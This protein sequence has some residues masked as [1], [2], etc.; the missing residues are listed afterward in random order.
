MKNNIGQLDMRTL[1]VH[2][3]RKIKIQNPDLRQ[4]GTIQIVHGLIE[5]DIYIGQ[6]QL[7][8]V[9]LVNFGQL[10]KA[11][12]TIENVFTQASQTSSIVGCSFHEGQGKFLRISNSNKISVLGNVFYSGIKAL[13]EIVDQKYLIFKNNILIHVKKAG[14]SN[15]A[16][17]ANFIFSKS[18]LNILRSNLD[19]T[20]NI[21][22]GSE[23]T[24]FYIVS[25]QCNQ[26]D[27]ANIYNNVCSSA[28]NACFAVVQRNSACDAISDLYAYHSKIGIMFSVNSRQLEIKKFITA[29]NKIN[30][31]LKGSSINEMNNVIKISDGYITAIARPTCITC[32]ENIDV[33]YCSS[34]LGMQLATMSSQSFL[35]TVDNLQSDQFDWINT[36]QVIDLRVLVNNLEFNQFKVN[37]N[38]VPN[39]VENAVFRQH[40]QAIDM[41]GRHYLKNTLC[42]DCEFESL[43]YRL[44][45]SDFNKIGLYGGCGSMEC[46]GQKNILI[47]DL[48]GDFFGEIGQGISNNTEFGQYAKYCKRIEQWNGYWCPGRNIQVLY[49]MS[50]APEQNTRLYSPVILSDGT[51]KNI[52]NSCYEWNW[53]ESRPQFT[54]QSKFIGLVSANSKIMLNTTGLQPT[55]SKFWLS[56]NSEVDVQDQVIISI[57]FDIKLM[58]KLFKNGIIISPSLLDSCGSYNYSFTKN[59]LE[60]TL[61]QQP[62]CYV[63]V[64]LF[65]YIAIKQKFL[66]NPKLNC[67]HFLLTMKRFYQI[68]TQSTVCSNNIDESRR[69]LGESDLVEITFE[70]AII[71]DAQPGTPE[72]Y[73]SEERLSKYVDKLSQFTADPDLGIYEILSQSYES[74]ILTD[75]NLPSSE[76]TELLDTT[77]SNPIV[78]NNTNNSDTSFQDLDI[79][80]INE[81]ESVNQD[82]NNNGK[83][84]I[85][86]DSE[87]FDDNDQ[88]QE[89]SLIIILSIV[90]PLVFIILITLLCIRRVQ[91]RKNQVV[92]PTI[93]IQQN[94]TTNNKLPET[95][96]MGRSALKTP[97]ADYNENIQFVTKI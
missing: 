32:Y 35:P 71:D 2:L 87:P 26:I 58:P 77:I 45:D 15:W 30:I 25:T 19:I 63:E 55:S 88:D 91:Q 97:K 21:G 41:T 14:P 60:F 51:N 89:Q 81:N 11:G 54:R 64:K 95:T 13:V 48:T 82:K 38:Q 50:T 67:I 7:Q 75:I 27:Q 96:F 66:A 31:I 47:E 40:P 52:L 78:Q 3:S 62:D 76:P 20:E 57:K 65:N 12:L 10:E 5:N 4:G 49:F 73:G 28:Q 93:Q 23:D 44:R 80:S 36:K 69:R 43:L 83:V 6:I 46:T 61:T 18:N 22:Q 1:V 90:V 59:K 74:Y 72:A 17:L 39:C 70:W 56:Q 33:N 85:S 37:N 16:V 34:T 94:E 53:I 84:I 42:T 9:E 24:G 92:I 79:I 8:G 68:D 86:K 29:E